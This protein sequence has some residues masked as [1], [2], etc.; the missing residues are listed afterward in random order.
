MAKDEAHA[1]VRIASGPE[2]LATYRA[3]LRACDREQNG[4]ANR[5]VWMT[6][7]S[8]FL[9]SSGAPLPCAYHRTDSWVDTG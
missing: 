9:K 2:V 7:S 5:N 6:L 8:N 1:A 3:L 4:N